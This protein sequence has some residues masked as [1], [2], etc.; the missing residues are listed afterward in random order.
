MTDEITLTIP[1]GKEFHRVA[2]LVLSGLG[3]R[4]NLTVETLE[5]LQIALAA[6]LDRAQPGGEITVAMSTRDGI[7]DTR[8]GPVDVRG[9]LNA[10]A[11]DELNLRRVLAA[12]VDD[13]E[14]EGEYV[15]LTKRVSTGG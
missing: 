9:E 15:R 14:V 2:H 13:V 7:L 6:I 3:L 8:V 4:L 11:D 12:V 5:D 1:G 10:P